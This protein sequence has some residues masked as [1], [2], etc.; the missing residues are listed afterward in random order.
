MV[1]EKRE[2]AKK[3]KKVEESLDAETKLFVGMISKNVDEYGVRELFSNFGEVR[4]RGVGGAPT[5]STTMSWLRHL[6]SLTQPS[7]SPFFVIRRSKRSS[8]FETKRG[9]A[10]AAR[11]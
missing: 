6:C 5:I 2:E 11:S 7:L 3:K 1:A 9:L 10:K 4:I 8:S